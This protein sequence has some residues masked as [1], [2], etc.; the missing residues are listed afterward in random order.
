MKMW[1]AK[2]VYNII[3]NIPVCFFL[4]LTSAISAASNF[5]EGVLMIAFRDINWLNMAI[6]FIVSFVLAMCIGL[7]IP[8]T[9]IGRWFTALFHVQNET[10][11]G[12]VRYRLLATLITS[13]IFFLIISPV[14]TIL[15][16]FILYQKGWQTAIFTFVINAPIMLL[17]G[18]ISSLLND[19]LAYKAAHRIDETF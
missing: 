5:N 11:T 1:G 15:N 18:F 13:L 2:I 10:Y 6:N 16:C 8:L 9:K 12:N 4:C 17:V 7:F 3:C 19:M 14:L